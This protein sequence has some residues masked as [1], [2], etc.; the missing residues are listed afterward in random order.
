VRPDL[1]DGPGLELV[2]EGVAIDAARIE[3]RRSAAAWKA[4]ALYQPAVPGLRSVPSFSKKT[5]RV[6]APQPKAATMR[7]ARP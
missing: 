2:A 7:E 1:L 5:P 3:A 6:S 4:A